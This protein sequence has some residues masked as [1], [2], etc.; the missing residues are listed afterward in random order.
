MKRFCM[1]MGFL[2]CTLPIYAAT[3]IYEFGDPTKEKRFKQ[4][5]HEL[6]CLVCQNQT[7]ADSNAELAG[8]LR[9]ELY[10][11]IQNDTSDSE[12]IDFM[13]SRYGDFVL[14]R[15][16]LKTTTYFLWF[17]PLIFIFVGLLTL[18]LSIRKRK[19]ISSTTLTPEQQQRLD[20]ILS[21]KEHEL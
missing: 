13:V 10:R 1:A 7:L 3:G 15:P 6:R 14:Y 9:R 18:T 17:G 12:I 8:D 20:R 16:P 11:M 19:R 21:R 4:F 2:I 5:S